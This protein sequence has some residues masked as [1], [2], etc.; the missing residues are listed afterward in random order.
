MDNDNKINELQEAQTHKEVQLFLKDELKNLT[1]NLQTK[2][3]KTL[4]KLRKQWYN[5]RV[6][7]KDIAKQEEKKK[8]KCIF[9]RSLGRNNRCDRFARI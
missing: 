8:K 9:S 1:N 6:N 3:Y 7:G 5:I 4:D 2:L